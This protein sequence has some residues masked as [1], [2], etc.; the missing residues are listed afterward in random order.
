M[1]TN[2]SRVI[3]Q[4]QDLQKNTCFTTIYG[5]TSVIKIG[6]KKSDIAKAE[7]IFTPL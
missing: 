6:C 5:V 1:S 4:I 7:L 3:E 2:I